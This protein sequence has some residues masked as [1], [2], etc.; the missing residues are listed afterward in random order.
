MTFFRRHVSHLVGSVI[1]A[2]VF[3]SVACAQTDNSNSL[4]LIVPCVA[5]SQADKLARAFAQVL[6]K[7]LGRPVYVDNLPADDTPALDTNMRLPT[8]GNSRI[9]SEEALACGE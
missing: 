9:P 2:I 1:A 3:S 5:G 4:R 6:T 8:D 7:D